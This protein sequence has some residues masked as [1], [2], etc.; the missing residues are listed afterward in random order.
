MQKI[1]YAQNSIWVWIYSKTKLAIRPLNSMQTRQHLPLSG[2]TTPMIESTDCE[3]WGQWHNNVQIPDH[4]QGPW[5]NPWNSHVFKTVIFYHPN[6]LVKQLEVDTRLIFMILPGSQSRDC[7]VTNQTNLHQARNVRGFA[8]ISNG[9]IHSGSLWCMKV[10]NG[11]HIVK[12][13]FSTETC[14]YIFYLS[15]SFQVLRHI[16]TR[17]TI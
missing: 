1:V 14:S 2:T 12:T 13:A 17:G 11:P 6:I 5:Q 15:G 4:F 7:S 8:C 10:Q 3:K 16:D 9:A